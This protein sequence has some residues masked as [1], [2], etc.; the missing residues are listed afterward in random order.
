MTRD[1]IYGIDLNLLL[2][3]HALLEEQNVT[4]AAARYGLTQSAM[5]RNLSR[6]RTLLDD[7]LLVRTRHGMRRTLRADA[8]R[9]PLR[10]LIADA[11][12]IVDQGAKFEP[13]EAVRAFTL[14]SA[15]YVE[16][17]LASLLL[18]HLATRAPGIDIVTRR[19]TRYAPEHLE[20]GEIDLALA[21]TT[22]IDGPG[23]RVQTLYED[24]FVCV[25]R[26]DHPK[27]RRLSLDDYC[28]MQHALSAPHESPGSI[29]DDALST[30][31][32]RRRVALT[33]PSFLVVGHVVAQ[34]DLVATLPR[35]S[36][37]FFRETL[38]LK[39]LPVPLEL[40]GFALGQFWHERRHGD[41]AHAWLREQI[42]IVLREGRQA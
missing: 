9:E 5:S 20:G 8:L 23:L 42:R 7:P 38:G 28:A 31:G 19:E 29:V 18:E 36:A 10:R 26:P 34:T 1:H 24:R 12:T 40:P 2:A 4:R 16:V 14:S 35:R 25:L 39:I 13:R 27:R 11:T 21:P 32:R 6:L 41:P 22:F 17:V 3:L 33:A 15:D 30:L 37:E